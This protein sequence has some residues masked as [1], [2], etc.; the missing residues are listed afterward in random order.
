MRKLLVAVAAL[1]ALVVPI[2]A[3]ASVLLGV[4]GSTSRF[5]DK[6]NQVSAVNLDF[7]SWG[8]HK[9]S[10]LDNTLNAAKPGIPVLS[11]RT[12][13]KYGHEAITPAGIAQG[14]GDRV[15]VDFA[16]A[17]T[18]FGGEAWVRPYPEMNGHWNPYCAYNESGS[19]RGRAHSTKNF[20]KAFRRTY[21]IMH[22]GSISEIN[23]K[24]VKAG[25]PKMSRT[26]DLPVN[27]VKVVWNPQ[28]FGSPDLTGNSAAAYF[29]GN[30]Y[31]D[32]VANDLYDY[33]RSVQW[34]ANL[35]LYRAHPEKPY[36]IGEWGL[37][38][39]IDHPEF[40]RRMAN[41]ASDHSRVAAIIF[42]ESRKGS[43]YD[44]AS[45][46]NARAAYKKYVLPLAN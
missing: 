45:K 43:G 30:G 31:V 40:V 17:L 20:R 46:P 1:V 3:S 36:A 19:Y 21:L 14:R 41:F 32:I 12:V 27:D 39:G 29:P 33:G 25:M 35:D 23:A 4:M 11:F 5:K 10:Y 38:P 24:L 22:G 42:Y 6:T 44:L 13:N 34:E 37:G 26:S 28:G 8:L 15:L 18:R 9:Q 2:Q 16:R 7:V